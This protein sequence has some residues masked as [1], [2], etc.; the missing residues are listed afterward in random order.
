V[1]AYPFAALNFQA[2]EIQLARYGY[3]SPDSL[4]GKNVCCTCKQ[5]VTTYAFMAKDGHRIETHSCPEHG[6][7][8]PM[9]SHIVNQESAR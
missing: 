1:T 9:R 7:V 2:P 3:R 6:D 4:M 8:Q 5:E